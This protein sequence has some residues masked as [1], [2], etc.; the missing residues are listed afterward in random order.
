MIPATVIFT[1]AIAAILLAA[2]WRFTR[3][4]SKNPPLPPGP[5]ALPILG[6][7]ASL[8]PELHS[9]FGS[10]ARKYG[11]ILRLQLGRK[12]GIVVSSPTVAREILKDQDVTF[13]NRDV[14]DV[15]RAI[16][17]GGSDIVWTPYGAE[18]RM[19]RKVCVL[20][21]LSNTTLDSVYGL[22]RREL[23]RTVGYMAGRAG[24]SVNFGEQMF[25]T[26]M[27]V[28]TSMM[29]GGTVEAGEERERL[30]AEF[31]RLVS[32]ITELLGQ[33]NLSDFFPALSR[34][35]LQGLNRKVNV[36]G[37]N[38]DR[39]YE[40]VIKKRGEMEREGKESSGVPDFLEFLLKLVKEEG[41]D[42]KTPLTM[43]HVKALL[44]DMI[45]GGTDTSAN[46]IEFA[47]AEVINNPRV[48]ERAQQELDEVVGRENIVEESHIHK[49][50]YLNCVM[51][52][53]LRLHPALPLLV[54]HC[55]SEDTVVAGY[56][57]PKGSRI[58]VNV[59]AIHRDPS[60]WEDPLEFKPERFLDESRWDYSGNDLS[61]FPFGSGRRICAGIAMAERMFLF[62]L[63]TFL[64]SFDWKLP[65]GKKSV[66]LTEKFGIVL[67]LKS[68]LVAI[69]VPRLPNPSQ[70]E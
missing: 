43:T 35:D 24:G 67:K 7:L 37:M 60:I 32:V 18:W 1:A 57:I 46:S 69:P 20:K 39:I 50:P 38:F 27:N 58:F 61:Y 34:F 48:L 21:M 6:N 52:E 41:G 23:R 2:I 47:M 10:L 4:A 13:A 68:P 17:Y 70:Y 8:D 22:R 56:S 51:K 15:A 30:G 44:M 25:L 11:P 66:D 63:A 36:A 5:P 40:E 53:S 9:Y 54:P 3:P 45:V 65:E 64:H 16:A 31:R 29:W 14:P 12:L 19:L 59:W 42:A 55:P 33:P 49:L 62:S 26:V 28:V